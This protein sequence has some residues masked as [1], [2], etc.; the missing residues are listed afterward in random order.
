M[1]D[2]RLG[3]KAGVTSTRHKIVINSDII[4]IY[5]QFV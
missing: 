5:I 3:E 2:Q 1:G 4:L